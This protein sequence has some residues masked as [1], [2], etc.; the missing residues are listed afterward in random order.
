MVTRVL[1][2]SEVYTQWQCRGSYGSDKALQYPCHHC[3][4]SKLFLV[5]QAR[6]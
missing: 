6:S 2:L 4:G 1:G 3:G 5:G